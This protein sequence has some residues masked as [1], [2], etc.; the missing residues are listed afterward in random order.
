MSDSQRST[1]TNLG[2]IIYHS[3][4]D[5]KP[6]NIDIDLKNTTNLCL[7]KDEGYLTACSGWKNLISVKKIVPYTF[8]MSQ[9]HWEHIKSK[10]PFEYDMALH[11]GLQFDLREIEKE[12]PGLI[13]TE[14]FHTLMYLRFASY[15]KSV[16][17]SRAGKALFELSKE[18]FEIRVAAS[19]KDIA[20]IK[21]LVPSGIGIFD[22][23]KY[24]A[25]AEAI[26]INRGPFF[27]DQVLYEVVFGDGKRW[28]RQ[29]YNLAVAEY[30][31]ERPLS[32]MR[33][34]G[35]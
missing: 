16:A 27:I 35:D 21:K 23:A 33:K 24:V 22:R 9:F 30:G 32:E 4:Y 28:N 26:P 19:Y 20:K 1:N 25:M 13:H 34:M 2:R 12:T 31:Y 8:G 18:V 11:F 14:Y 17:T 6:V 3:N 10:Q 15:L 29:A 7:E 5:K